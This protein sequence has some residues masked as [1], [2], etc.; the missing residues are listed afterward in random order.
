MVGWQGHEGGGRGGNFLYKTY[1][2]NWGAGYFLRIQ[3]NWRGLRF[4]FTSLHAT[5]Q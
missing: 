2:L 1:F 4:F 3:I 5:M